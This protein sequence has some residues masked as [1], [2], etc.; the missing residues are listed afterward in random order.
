MVSGDGLSFRA[1][2]GGGPRAQPSDEASR[3]EAAW[4]EHFR[5]ELRQEARFP[6]AQ[7]FLRADLAEALRR[8]V[9]AR[10]SVL[11]L[12]VGS[13]SLL[14]SLPNRVRAGIDLLPEA[15][16]AAKQRDPSLRLE[17][18]DA[19]EYSGPER[20][21]AVICDRLCH[22]VADIQRLLE[23]A[24]AQL[25][26]GGRI[27]FVCFNF[28]WQLP[29]AAAARLGFTLPT[30]PH[31]WLS[32]A[33][34]ENLFE[35]VGL[36]SVRHEDRVLVPARVPVV[37]GVLNRFLARVPPTHLLSLYRIYVLR[38]R[39]TQ[40]QDAKVSVVV[41][42]RNEAGNIAAAIARTP[43][44]GKGT[45]LIFVEGGSSDGTFERIEELI[46][47]YDGP[48]KL[49]VIRQPGSGKGDAVRAGFER[50]TG[51][52]LMI[53]DAD[54]TVP[55]EDLP[56]F[57]EVMRRGLCDYAHGT[58]LVYPMEK[59]AMRFLNKLGNAFFAKTFTFL[60]NQPIKDTL[61]GTKVLWRD[62]YAELARNRHYFGDFD[63]FGDF[64]LIF[65]ATRLNL[66]M[67]EIP[68]RYRSRTYG[69]TNISRFR[70]GLLLLRM[71]LVAAR[72]LKFA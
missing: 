50:A 13:G 34:F 30:P 38:R 9:P 40:R 59:Q 44:M 10:A 28:M 68:I 24:A 33:D 26:N 27:Y 5:R 56:R 25:A 18:A 32:T 8:L 66:K 72:R 39:D 61:C 43:V 14:A 63:P 71:S 45:E 31:N 29:T 1:G 20:Y 36:Q 22:S 15:V 62:D 7:R 17:V 47:S 11:E 57:Y 51:D 58:R 65:G 55:P 19:L 37:E 2:E 23:N 21:D 16:E 35:L 41:P 69:E 12:G 70:H 64:D 67:I 4:R 48:L 6:V 54:L 53:L 49:G 60:L 52:L 46:Q 3:L 42:A